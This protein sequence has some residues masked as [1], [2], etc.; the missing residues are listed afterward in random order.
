MAGQYVVRHDVIM[1]GIGGRGVLMAGLL[2][3]RA[4]IGQYENVVWF[5]SYASAM[6]GGPCECTVILSSDRIASPLLTQTGTVVIIDASQLNSFEDR[7]QPGGF[8]STESTGAPERIS[9]EDVKFIRISGVEN[10]VA[11]G[12]AQAANLVLLGAYIEFTRAVAPE[13]IEEE[14]KQSGGG[15]AKALALNHEAFRCG[16]SLA[17]EMKNNLSLS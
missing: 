16:L 11:I 17:A 14:M 5:P 13:L 3:A 10:A 7:V 8:I 15:V 9:R 2:L 6:R 12:S 4:A 1:G